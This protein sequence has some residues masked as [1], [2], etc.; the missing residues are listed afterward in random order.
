MGTEHA[1]HTILGRHGHDVPDVIARQHTK[2]LSETLRSI[3]A[4]R[5]E[6]SA[7]VIGLFAVSDK[8]DR[9]FRKGEGV[10]RGKES[11][12]YDL[13]IHLSISFLSTT[14]RSSENL[15]HLM[16]LYLYIPVSKQPHGATTMY[17][18]LKIVAFGLC[19]DWPAF[20]RG[21]MN[22]W[23]FSVNSNFLHSCSARNSAWLMMEIGL[24][25]YRAIARCSIRASS[26]EELGAAQA[27]TPMPS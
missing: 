16:T 25:D 2:D 18:C 20:A 14:Q 22:R 27:T 24:A 6:P 3:F 23:S 10:R 12:G 17:R 19:G 26:R 9:W 15:G 11:G 1:V 8:I 7:S 21:R 4:L 13:G 5:A